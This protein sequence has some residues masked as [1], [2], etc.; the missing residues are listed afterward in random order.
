MRAFR[1]GLSAALLLFA[2]LPTVAWS[3]VDDLFTKLKVDA[4][5]VVY[6]H[7]TG[8]DM[9]T[10]TVLA[11]DYPLP[12]LQVR[13]N[14]IGNELGAPARGLRVYKEGNGSA[15]TGS[16]PFIKADFATNGIVNTDGAIRLQPIVRALT[17]GAGASVVSG[18]EIHVQGVAA[19]PATLMN[20]SSA[21]LDLQGRATSNPKALEFRVAVHSQ[22]PKAI[23]IPDRNVPKVAPTTPKDSGPA[24]S[25]GVVWTLVIV[26]AL[27]ASAL[28]YN[29]ALRGSARTH[30]R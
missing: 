11:P 27:A 3:Q 14:E 7:P 19:S 17:G 23:E 9:V 5:I 18:L 8:A 10:I 21:A 15:A 1:A 4:S 24:V 6:K 2:G 29:L 22:D 30:R 26:G 25:P 16:S 12:E 20:F 28:V 13:A